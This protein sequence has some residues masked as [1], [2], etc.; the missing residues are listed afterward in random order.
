MTKREQ[1]TIVMTGRWGHRL[2]NMATLTH[3]RTYSLPPHNLVL[4]LGIGAAE[5]PFGAG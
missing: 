3:T 5:G 2:R 1:N 4:L